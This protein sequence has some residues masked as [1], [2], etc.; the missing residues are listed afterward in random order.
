MGLLERLG[1]PTGRATKIIDGLHPEQP[2]TSGNTPKPD[3]LPLPAGED[4]QRAH[5]KRNVLVAITGHD[6]DCET[7]TMACNIAK[8]KKAG[9]YAIY[10]IE[11]PR[12]LAIDA[13]LPQETE[14]ASEAL[15]RA[16]AVADQMHMRIDPEIVQSRNFGQSLVDE[17][18]AH[19]CALVILGLPYHLGIGGH[20]DLGETADYV[21]KNAPCRVWLIRGQRPENAERAER[22]ERRE[23][24]STT[25]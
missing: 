17:A 25:L 14:A 16:A 9:V 21:L 4:G 3:M 2:H 6:L 22:T 7:V 10:G 11:V 1:L 23:S 12:K 15:E 24:I 20:F 18:R 5:T 13:E 8:M 19:E